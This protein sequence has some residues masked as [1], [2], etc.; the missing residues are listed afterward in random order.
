MTLVPYDKSSHPATVDGEVVQELRQPLSQDDYEKLKISVAEIGKWR[1]TVLVML[2]RATGLRISEVLGSRVA[3]GPL[4]PGQKG[5][6]PERIG[7]E[8]PNVYVLV[9]RGK[10]KA[11]D[12][13]WERIY[14]PPGFASQLEQYIKGNHIGAMD[15]LFPV[16]RQQVFQLYQKAGRRA[17]GRPINPHELRA[18][19]ETH[20]IQAMGVPL[21]VASKMLGHKD[22]KVTM[23]HYYSVN[24]EEKKEIQRRIPA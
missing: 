15:L 5:L 11:K 9:W 14:L 19:Y 24:A 16:S 20:L 10:K 22:I 6:T 7:R 8:G 2:L 18:L 4:R 13:G 17:I 3:K 1:D 21:P 12:Q 23:E